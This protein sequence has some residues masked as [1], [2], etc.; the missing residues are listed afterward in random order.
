MSTIEPENNKALM[1]DLKEQSRFLSD[2]ANISDSEGGKRLL[3]SMGKAIVAGINVLCAR[4]SAMGEMEIRAKLAEVAE[5]LLLFNTI[6][7]ARSDF[8][9]TQSELQKYI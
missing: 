9:E 8:D 1:E 3:E 6:S 2:L 4:Q 7:T 5:K